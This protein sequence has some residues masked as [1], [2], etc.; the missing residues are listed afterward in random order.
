MGRNVF[1][2]IANDRREKRE[3]EGEPR[4]NRDRDSSY[5]QRSPQESRGAYGEF[6]KTER[7]EGFNRSSNFDENKTVFIGNLDFGVT[8]DK[9]RDEFSDC[10]SIAKLKLPKHLDGNIKGMCFIEFDSE[11]SVE[12]AVRKTGTN[13][14]G[15]SVRV[16]KY[17]S[18]PPP[19]K[20][21]DGESRSYS[22][23][24]AGRDYGRDSGRDGNRDGNRDFRSRSGSSE[25]GNRNYSKRN[26]RNEDQSD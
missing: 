16:T 4:L 20:Y 10:G 8:E 11:R 25:G 14:N 6:P 24:P 18:T 17:T 1:A 5:S 15:R 26:M 19:K 13:L 7:A 3:G 9:I 12:E 21:G 2:R 22:A 23:R